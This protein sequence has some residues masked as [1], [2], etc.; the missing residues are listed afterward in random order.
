MIRFA[1][2]CVC[3]HRF[4][5]W[6]RDNRG[7]E[8]LSAAGCVSCPA[9]GGSEVVK[10]PMAPHVTTSRAV[11]PISSDEATPQSRLREVLLTLRHTVEANCENVGSAFAEE[12]RK[13]HYGETPARGIYGEASSDDVKSL[14]EEDILFSPLPWVSR[15]DS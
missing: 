9:C 13:I 7:F 2:R 4:D 5:S 15:E 1:L 6:F 12:A 8:D 11:T 10:A 14:V 3:G